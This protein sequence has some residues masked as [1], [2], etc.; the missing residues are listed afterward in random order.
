M[1]ELLNQVLAYLRGIWRYRWVLMGTGWLV[2]VVGWAYV[3]RM[4]DEYR[5]SATIHVDTDTVLRPLLRG[6]A[7]STDPAQ[8]VAMMTRTLVTRPNLEKLARMT[9]LDLTAKS[10]AEMERLINSLKSRLRVEAARRYNLYTI[11]FTDPDRDLAKRVVQSLLTIFVE[12][13]LGRSRED[14]DAAQRFLEDQIKQYAAKLDEAEKRLA[15]FKRRHVGML[16]G[17]GADYYARLQKALSELEAARLQLKELEQR[18]EAQIAQLEDIEMAG[19]AEEESLLPSDGVGVA[20]TYDLRIQNLQ[21]QLD[22][23]LLRFTERHPDVME[24]RRLIADLE[25]KREEELAAMRPAESSGSEFSMGDGLAQQ[26]RLMLSETEAQIAAMKARVE[27]Y[28][29]GVKKLRDAVDTLPKVEAELKRLNRDYQVH[30]ANYEQLLKRREQVNISEQADISADD[31]KFRIVEPPQ[32]PLEPDGPNRI[33]FM[34]MVLGVA[35]GAGVAVAFVLSQLNPTFD[36]A[37]SLKEFTGK[38]VF[39]SISMMFTEEVQRKRY[40]ALFSFV[41][42]GVSLVLV[43]GVAVIVELMDLSVLD[44]LRDI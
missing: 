42:A 38:P 21:S 31:V 40:L 27:A 36:D 7:V 26:Y 16:P 37:K 11:S 23:L 20:S 25:R 5:A 35:L 18:R 3:L 15:D 39:G 33:L 9:D 14:T 12:S 1:Y 22:E 6:L 19:E 4:P 29:N 32:V 8:R 10:P 44:R 13:N 43:Y 24:L 28:E 41:V 17:E 34:T 30:K 2:A